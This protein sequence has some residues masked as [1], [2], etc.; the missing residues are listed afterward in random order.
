[1]SRWPVSKASTKATM[2]PETFV[3]SIDSCID[4]RFG[5]GKLGFRALVLSFTLSCAATTRRRGEL[6]VLATQRLHRRPPRACSPPVNASISRDAAMS[7]NPHG[8]SFFPTFFLPPPKLKTHTPRVIAATCRYSTGE[9]FLPPST[10]PP[11]MT[12]TILHDL[13]RT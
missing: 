7:I 13:P 5:P 8:L 10:M 1:L 4:G 12:G 3:H 6:V 9:Y 11:A 2:Q